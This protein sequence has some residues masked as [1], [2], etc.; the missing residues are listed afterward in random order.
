M[1]MKFIVKPKCGTKSQILINR[2]QEFLNS[3]EESLKKSL[4]N[5][6]GDEA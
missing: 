6:K 1:D 2:K 4:A 3:N 5:Y